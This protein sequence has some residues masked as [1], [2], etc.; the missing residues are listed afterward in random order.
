MKKIYGNIEINSEYD[1]YGWLN[2]DKNATT[3]EIIKASAE[4]QADLLVNSA[5]MSG[6]DVATSYTL[7]NQAT[8]ILSDDELR[9]AYDSLVEEAKMSNGDYIDQLED[10]RQ[11]QYDYEDKVA[12]VDEL[13]KENAAKDEYIKELEA[14]LAEAE[15][16]KQKIIEDLN[17]AVDDIQDENGVLSDEEADK[18]VD[19]IM[20]AANK[21]EDVTVENQDVDVFTDDDVDVVNND[22]VVEETTDVRVIPDGAIQVVKEEKMLVIIKQLR[23]LQLY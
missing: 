6:E 7:L 16:Q 22:N 8:T 13:T 12:Q 11:S 10:Q 23:L 2:V 19:A 9:K 3:E 15:A 17:N 18:V 5:N 1:Y 20:D 4:R 14:K 21:P